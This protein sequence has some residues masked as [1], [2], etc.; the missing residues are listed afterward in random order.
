M[1][2]LLNAVI[3][4]CIVSCAALVAESAASGVPPLMTLRQI[5]ELIKNTEYDTALLE[6]NA[7]LEAHPESFDSVQKRISRI[8]KL[9]DGYTL[10]ANELLEAIREEPDNTEKLGALSRK[11]LSIERNPG[12]RRLDIIK[13]TDDVTALARYSRYQR[14]SAELTGDGRFVEG[15]KSAAAGFFLYRND[16]STAYAGTERLAEVEQALGEVNAMLTQYEQLQKKLESAKNAYI[17]AVSGASPATADAALETVKSV[18]SEF[19]DL[20]N[21]LLET[22]DVF[23]SGAEDAADTKGEGTDYAALFCRYAHAAVLGRKNEEGGGIAGAMDTQWRTYVEEMKNA[24]ADSVQKLSASFASR[25]SSENISAAANAQNKTLLSDVQTV[26]DYGLSVN[27]LYGLLKEKGGGADAPSPPNYAL[28]MQYVGNEAQFTAGALEYPIA[29]VSLQ[30]QSDFIEFGSDAP[31]EELAG[32]NLAAPLFDAAKDVAKLMQKPSDAAAENSAWRKDYDAARKKAEAARPAEETPAKEDEL[33]ADRNGKAESRKKLSRR[34]AQAAKKKAL[35]KVNDDIIAWKDMDAAAETVSDSFTSHAQKVRSSII[36]KA[37]DFY[38]TCGNEYV[39]SAE[40]LKEEAIAAVAAQKGKNNADAP[41]KHPQKALDTLAS[42]DDH[43]ARAKPVLENALKNI[44]AAGLS[45]NSSEAVAVQDA[46]NKLSG[47][48]A[49]SASLSANASSLLRSAQK[50]KNEAESRLSQAERALDA[51]EFTTARKRLEEAGE[52]FVE[53]LSYN[54]DDELR[55][56]SDA[57]IASLGEEIKL[58]ENIDVVREV[59]TLKNSARHEYFNGNFEAAQKFLTQ[60]AARWAVTNVD[61]DTEIADL[62]AMVETA[63]S[64][65]TGRIMFPSDSL[66]PEMSQ[67]LSIAHQYYHQ[68]AALIKRGNRTEGNAKLTLALQKLDELRIVYPLNQDANLLTLRIQQ[69]RDPAEFNRRFSQRVSTAKDA[70]KN[71]ETRR[72]TYTDLLDLYAIDPSYP[73]LKQLIYD[74]EIEIGIRVKPVK[75]TEVDRSGEL[76]TQARSLFKSAGRGDSDTLRRAMAIIDR[77]IQMNAENGD[78]L[79]LKDEISMRLGGNATVVLSSKDLELYNRAVQALNEN[80]ILAA[81]D[82]VETLLRTSGN[83]NSS[84]I[85]ELQRRIKA[86]N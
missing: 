81:N 43:V 51:S 63:L 4:L 42:L 64:M 23:G 61:E 82:M 62:T 50:A 54:D 46:L 24:S 68:G 72:S 2:R 38:A 83:R 9:R 17:S 12:D 5:D 44:Y 33:Q 7:Y 20:R 53:S 15:A 37:A 25:L 11:L 55:A 27:S 21:R 85:L 49:F 3:M 71:P 76:V 56:S 69:L 28:S 34:T 80:N 40:K 14:K 79:L 66:Y 1:R 26:A 77:A 60:A 32:K 47:M 57:R 10:L 13:D 52:K 39:D 35:L 48:N 36:K 58:R 31:K 75:R 86:R 59:R 65:K 30:Q 22:A 84:R 19:A 18:F 16:F 74:V 45:R 8:M 6:L 78:A 73:G 29:A 70:L 41:K 67:I